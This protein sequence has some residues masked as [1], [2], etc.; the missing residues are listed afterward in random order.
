MEA[1]GFSMCRS[2]VSYIIL[3]VHEILLHV[4]VEVLEMALTCCFQYWLTPRLS[5]PDLS[6]S[7]WLEMLLIA[8]VIIRQLF[9]LSSL[10]F[11]P[12]A[13]ES[14]IDRSCTRHTRDS[15]YVWQSSHSVRNATLGRVFISIP[16]PP[17]T[18]Y[19]GHH[20]GVRSWQAQVAVFAFHPNSPW[21]L[22]L[23][24]ESPQGGS[25][26]PAKPN[27]LEARHPISPP[28]ICVE[29]GSL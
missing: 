19:H 12:R 18:F 23:Q 13:S 29:R 21:R 2:H 24:A 10:Y 28:S 7:L 16:R 5:L 14:D 6:D 17:S 1:L 25:S 3:E 22:Y 4:R 27:P 20:L 26:T 15:S 9:T 11:S 8:A